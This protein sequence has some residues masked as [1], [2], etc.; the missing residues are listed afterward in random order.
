MELLIKTF[1]GLEEVLAAEL[2][3]LGAGDIQLLP[4][5]VRC[6]GDKRLLYRANYEL[7]TALRVL[8]PIHSFK[9]KHENHFYK[10]VREI[11]WTKYLDLETTF[12]IDAVTSS[13]YLTHSRYLVYKTKDA[14]LDQMR[15]LDEERRRPSIDTKTPTWRFHVYISSE[16]LCTIYLDSSNETLYKRGYRLGVGVAP[17]SEVLAA[18]MIALSGWKGD[19]PFVDPMCGSG[20]IPIEAAMRAYQIPAQYYRKDFGF[21]RWHDFDKELWEE[22]KTV[23]NSKIKKTGPPIHGSD[24]D[25]EAFKIAIK[26]IE[27]ANLSDKIEI[28]WHSM[29][30]LQ[31][32]TAPGMLIFNPPYDERMPEEDI[33]QFYKSI[34]DAMK[35]Q[36]SGYDAWI[37]SSNR[38]AL[39]RIGLRASRKIILFNGPLECRFQHYELYRGT[40]R[41]EK[42][43]TL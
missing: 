13:K 22:V 39:K 28:E 31:A 33:V 5:A 4:R 21:F 34:G 32:P 19:C 12:A 25:V 15:E 3:A 7:R 17:I 9:T 14:I 10:K 1:Q 8:M 42:K 35:Q 20:T 40:R 23:A 27:E 37:I 26:N 30:R 18:G 24:K 29:H 36:F 38:D 41:Q 2:R 43:E 16:N 11:D 6:T